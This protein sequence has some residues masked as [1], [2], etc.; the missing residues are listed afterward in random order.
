MAG[1]LQAFKYKREYLYQTFDKKKPKSKLLV[2]TKDAIE[3]MSQFALKNPNYNRL[4]VK[5]D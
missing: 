5:A 4:F 2:E 3:K 1:T